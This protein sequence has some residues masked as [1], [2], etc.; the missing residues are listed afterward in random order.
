[1]TKKKR[2]S[3]NK[4]AMPYDSMLCAAPVYLLIDS[5]GGIACAKSD[6]ND[7]NKVDEDWERFILLASESKKEIC[8]EAN[9]GNYGANC[10]VA[11][12]NGQIFWEW[13]NEDGKWRCT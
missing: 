1:M 6:T 10:V 12:G 11:N 7:L 4:A 13:F 9:T 8:H 2:H 3:N 5:R